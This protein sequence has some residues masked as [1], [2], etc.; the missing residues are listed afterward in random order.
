MADLTGL[1]GEACKRV[2]PYVEE[3]EQGLMERR[4]GGRGAA[5][6]AGELE[7]HQGDG[8]QGL[9]EVV[10]GRARGDVAGGGAGVAQVDLPARVTG[11]VV[12]ALAATVDALLERQ[13][14]RETRVRVG[15]SRTRPRS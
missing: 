6:G 14:A 15:S 13:L 5:R 4:Q 11:E 1:C 3:V 2:V 7:R 10:A 12:E 9:E 8:P